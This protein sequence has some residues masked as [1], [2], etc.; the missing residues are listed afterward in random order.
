L[1]TA[2][3]VTLLTDPDAWW[4]E[5]AQ[6]LIFERQDRSVAGLL[7]A[8]VK[9]R[10]SALGRL[11]ALWALDLLGVLDP[12]TILLGLEDPEPRVREQAVRL[13]EGRLRGE[14]ILLAKLLS[15]TDDPDPMVRFQLAFSLGEGGADPRV[16]AALANLSARDVDSVWTQTAVLRS[17]AGRAGSLVAALAARETFFADRRG[18]AWLEPLAFLVGSEENAGHCLRLL[19]QLGIDRI[20]EA[21]LMR[22]AHALARGRQRI[23]GSGREL[24]EAKNSVLMQSLL[25]RASRV[26]AS[27]DGSDDRLAAIGLLALMGSGAERKVLTGLLDA[28]QAVVIQLAALKALAGSLDH[29]TARAIVAHWN[30]MSPAVR[31]EGVEVLFGRPDGIFAILVALES[32]EIKLADIDPSRLKRLETQSDPRVRAQVQRILAADQGSV[33]DRSQT[34]AAYA[35]ATHLPGDREAGRKVFLKTCATCHQAEGRGVNVG[36]DL[37]TVSGRSPGDLLTHILD[38][39]REVATNFVNYSVALKNGRIVSGMIADESASALT[40]KRAEGA[41]D[42]IARDQID[43]IAATG[44]SL[45]PD[46][47]EKGL[48]HQDMADLITFVRSIGAVPSK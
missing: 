38:P 36:P 22:V 30:A 27:T 9:E 41:S 47:L 35:P 26:A 8:M 28:R 4:R 21:V 18:Q 17:I 29:D 34:I 40:L 6:R 44:V 23:G 45:M 31:R 11:H 5:T 3:L 42:V 15:M 19:D 33:R 10:P 46:G 32:R 39:N 1:T 20:D 25:A 13:A 12:S 37:S 7:V 48:S 2:A 43:A 24:L 16:I 14:P